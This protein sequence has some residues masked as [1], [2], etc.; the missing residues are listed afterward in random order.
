MNAIFARFSFLIAGAILGGILFVFLLDVILMPFIVDVQSVRIPKIIGMPV[1][2]ATKKLEQ[3]GLQAVVADS[4]FSEK[5]TEGSILS[6]RPA[7]GQRVKQGRAVTLTISR[8]PRLYT[9]PT[10]KGSSL[11]E[12]K[13]KLEASILTVGQI[14]YVSS[15]NIPKTVV[16]DQSPIA[17][18]MLNKHGE[19]N[20][21]VSSG[22]EW[23]LK[24]TPHLINASVKDVEDSLLKYEM[25]LGKISETVK[26]DI[27]P[28][29]VLEQKP[30]AGI[31]TPRFT[32]IDLVITTFTEPEPR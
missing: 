10:V 17:K 25:L 29:T 26:N 4:A 13:L 3:W 31:K 1:V 6:L 9:V 14:R 11:R 27:P 30:R 12:A 20:L 22:S 7:T 16:I 21:Y 28:G 5:I 8:G 23:D 32:P 18:S 19:V 2:Q 15:D 24:S